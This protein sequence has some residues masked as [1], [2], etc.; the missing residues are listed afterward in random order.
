MGE[1][2]ETLLRDLRRGRPI[3]MLIAP[4]AFKLLGNLDKVLGFF[5]RLGVR[6]F[7]PVLPYAD[8][9]LWAYFTLLKESGGLFVCSACAGL[10]LCLRERD[11]CCLA[12]VYSPLLCAA[13]YLR[14]YRFLDGDF[15]FL[16][17]C[18][19]KEKEFVTPEGEN[20]VRYN[21]TIREL[22]GFTAPG[23]PELSPCPALKPEQDDFCPGLTLAASGSVGGALGAL[24]PGKKFVVKRGLA[25]TVSWLRGQDSHSNTVLEAYA[26]P[27]GC[28]YGSGTGQKSKAPA[29]TES[30]EPGGGQAAARQRAEHTEALRRLF[31]RYTRELRFADFC[32][33]SHLPT[34]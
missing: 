29:G 10:N 34:V 18:Q 12:P 19:L 23:D 15:A 26:C 32:Y 1:G 24:L 33:P 5:R 8:I 21:V 3:R 30:P 9:T 28:L 13:R 6:S 22:A 25:E 27:G 11:P 20:L 14:T 16:S 4:A 2:L 17:P 31:D 7:H